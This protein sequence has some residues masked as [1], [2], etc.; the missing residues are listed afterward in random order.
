MVAGRAPFES[1]TRQETSRKIRNLE[2]QMPSH[3]SADLCDFIRKLLVMD[4]K[5]RL[6][7]DD[8]LNHPW[9]RRSDFDLLA[10]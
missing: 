7:E 5:L 8:A 9:I 4:P 6:H 3:F 1:A 2:F 10:N